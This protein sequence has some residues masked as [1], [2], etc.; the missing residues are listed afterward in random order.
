ML[1]SCACKC[2]CAPFQKVVHDWSARYKKVMAC[3]SATMASTMK[4]A[5]MVNSGKTGFA[6]VA[7]EAGRQNNGHHKSQQNPA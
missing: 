7:A 6:N 3:T 5:Q 2:S 1:L 4:T